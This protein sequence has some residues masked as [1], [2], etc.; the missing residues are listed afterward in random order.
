MLS[1]LSTIAR[2][3]IRLPARRALTVAPRSRLLHSTRPV[4]ATEGGNP[5]AHL[6]DNPVLQQVSSN[7]AALAAISEFV[8]LLQ[9]KG[10][11]LDRA[12]SGCSS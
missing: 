10:T 9:S 7:P 12:R 4:L 8:Q 3:S 5:L 6:K 1:P 11:R 2:S